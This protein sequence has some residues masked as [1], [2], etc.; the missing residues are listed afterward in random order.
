MVALIIL[1]ACYLAFLVLFC[2]CVWVG[3]MV[4]DN[5]IKLSYRDG[6]VFCNYQDAKK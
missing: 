2:V 5:D 1:A 6:K 4:H 3:K